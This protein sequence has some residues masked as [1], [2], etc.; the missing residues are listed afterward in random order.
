[1]RAC[2]VLLALGLTL[3]PAATVGQVPLGPLFRVNTYTTGDQV[4]PRVAMNNAGVFVVTWNSVGQD[5]SEDGV[6]ARSF[7]QTGTPFTPGEFQVNATTLGPQSAPVVALA[8]TGDL[9]FAWQASGTY[10]YYGTHTSQDIF[11]RSV[12]HDGVPAGNEFRVNTSFP[13]DQTAPSMSVGGDIFVGAP[14]FVV[15]WNSREGYGYFDMSGRTSTSSEFGV[16]SFAVNR[17]GGA[18]ASDDAGGFV[19]TWAD[20]IN[21][22]D[23]HVRA[24]RFNASGVPTGSPVLVFASGRSGA[25]VV[26]SD[27]AGNFVV[28]WPT[29]YSY[30]VG[31]QLMAR[32]YDAASVPLGDA[33]VVSAPTNYYYVARPGVAMDRRGGF[34]V[35]WQ[36]GGNYVEYAWDVLAR[37]F[38]ASGPTGP[39]FFVHR[40]LGS[41]F[42]P[43]VDV[44]H[45]GDFVVTWQF[46][47]WDFTTDIGARRFRRDLIFR[48]GFDRGDL[49]AWSAGA[50]DGGDLTVDPAASLP[51]G[52]A[53]L[54]GV[55]DDVAAIYVQDDTPHDERRYRARF[56]FDP[57]GFDPG[58]AQAHLRTRMLIAFT[59]EPSRRVAA[60][61]LRL[62]PSGQY[63]L[64][65]RARLDDNTQADTGFV[66]ISD[67]PHAVEFDLT[68]ATGPDALDG[69]FRLY[70]DGVLQRQRAALDNSLAAVDFVRMGALSA[71]SGASGTIYWDGFESRRE[72][73]IGP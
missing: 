63:S 60:I 15:V 53:G 71:K 70:V 59:E 67:A 20:D 58:V 28:V 21:E 2:A 14:N 38:D 36:E 26:A 31:Y 48:D 13:G 62:Q 69:S 5:G 27:P 30:V 46:E 1:M 3:V 19:V 47:D 45:A 11:A 10:E 23:T 52:G 22:Y 7:D 68:P 56:W 43:S 4:L 57:N 66:L 25:P 73:Y 65:G 33:F 12:G 17:K 40:D 32:R 6:F 41:Q 42:A 18:V 39:P 44:N 8:D 49:S 9:L 16:S 55:V 61:V 64:M 50:T 35:T 51:S 34:V 72:G 24:R 54:R 29:G 37:T